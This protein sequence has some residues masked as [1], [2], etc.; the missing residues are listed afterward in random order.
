MQGIPLLIITHSGEQQRR[1]QRAYPQQ[2]VA[3][4]SEALGI[5]SQC[6]HRAVMIDLSEQDKAGYDAL[7]AVLAAE[8]AGDVTATPLLL[9]CSTQAETHREN[10]LR[11]K[12]FDNWVPLPFC[13]EKIRAIPLTPQPDLHELYALAGQQQPVIDAMIPA[14]LHTLTRDLQRLN[15]L[16]R[17][18]T[19]SQIADLA[20]RMKSSFHLLGMRYARRSCI[21]MERLPALIHERRLSEVQGIKIRHR[22]GVVIDEH[23]QFLRGA[24]RRYFE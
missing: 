4:I 20:H 6:R 12:G 14:L 17:D 21:T 24:L 16:Q 19:L 1:L 3:G 23:Y 10:R 22:F 2:K 9:A 5:L 8:L 15:N 13:S 7:D 18:G 11:L